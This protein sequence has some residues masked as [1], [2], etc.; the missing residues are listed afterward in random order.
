MII[1]RLL[2]QPTVIQNELEATQILQW[3]G[4][5]PAYSRS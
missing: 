1:L 2:R 5:V 4:R 3:P